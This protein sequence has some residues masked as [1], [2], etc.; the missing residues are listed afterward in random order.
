MSPIENQC[1]V[2][3]GGK[4][5]VM[6]R[7]INHV[8]FPASDLKRAVAFYQNVLG[9]EKKGEWPNYAILT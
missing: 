7:R 5:G 9:L 6:I 8:T 1:S 4:V 2:R 3:I